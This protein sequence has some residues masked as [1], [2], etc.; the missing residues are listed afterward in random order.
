MDAED[1]MLMPAPRWDGK[2]NDSTAFLAIVKS[3][4]INSIRDLKLEHVPLLQNV[5]DKSTVGRRV[6]Q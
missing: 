5:L 6:H 2:V 3:R 1:F 4:N